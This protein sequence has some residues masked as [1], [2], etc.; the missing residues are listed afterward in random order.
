MNEYSLIYVDIIQTSRFV[1]F[2]KSS[3]DR[4]DDTNL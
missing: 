4:D 1:T 3:V 2:F